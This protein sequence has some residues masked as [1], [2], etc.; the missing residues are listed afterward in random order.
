[1]FCPDS[2]QKELRLMLIQIL[3]RGPLDDGLK[4]LVT[5]TGTGKAPLITASKKLCFT[6]AIR[7]WSVGSRLQALNEAKAQML[8]SPGRKEIDQ[9]AV[10]EPF[11][12]P[13]DDLCDTSPGNAFLQHLFGV[14]EPEEAAGNRDNLLIADETP[15]R[16]LPL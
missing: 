10:L 14:C 12:A 5:F 15:N 8:A 1:M 7:D 3:T 9:L 6:A 2:E 13:P 4:F 16:G 11:A